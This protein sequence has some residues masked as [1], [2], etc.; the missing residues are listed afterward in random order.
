MSE[1]S[2]RNKNLVRPRKGLKEKERRYKAHR[3]RLVALGL[4][5]EDVRKMDPKKMRTLLR[6]PAKLAK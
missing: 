3:Q 5:E 2:F 1:S 4:P 6:H